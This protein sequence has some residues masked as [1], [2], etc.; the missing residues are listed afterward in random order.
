MAKAKQNAVVTIVHG[1]AYEKINELTKPSRLA[2]ARRIGA[3]F[4]TMRPAAEWPKDISFPWF[5]MNLFQKLDEWDRII[6]MDA[7]LIVSPDC[8]NLFDLV[9]P[10]HLGAFEEGKIEG[11]QGS[12]LAALHDYDIKTKRPYLGSYFNSGLMV[13][14]K[15]HQH[16]FIWPDNNKTVDNYYEQS[17]L[18]AR[19]FAEYL[20]VMSLDYKFNR[21]SCMDLLTGE[22]RHAAHIIHYAGECHKMK[23][24]EYPDGRKEKEVHAEPL[25]YDLIKDDLKAW[26][27]KRPVKRRIVV[28]CSGGI[29][30]VVCSEPILRYA[31]EKLY[32]DEREKTSFTILTRYRKIFEHL[33]SNPNV[34]V[35]S[36]DGEYA[37]DIGDWFKKKFGPT[38]PVAHWKTHP[39]SE[40]VMRMF[41]PYSAIHNL[42]FGMISLLRDSIPV[43]HKTPRLVVTRADEDE[44]VQADRAMATRMDKDVIVH[45]GTGWESKTFPVEYWTEIINRLLEGRKRVIIIGKGMNAEHGVLPVGWKPEY[46]GSVI[47]LRDKLSMGA[48]FAAIKSAPVLLTND[49]S[50]VHI[51]GAFDNWI[52]MLATCKRPDLVFPFRHGTTSYK[53]RAVYKK[54]T[55]ELNRPTSP[56]L[57]TIDELE[58]NILDYLETPERVVEVVDEC[59]FKAGHGGAV[60]REQVGVMAK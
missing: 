9:P 32:A 28:E 42:D 40:H 46:G 43:E 53:T 12:L 14:S 37:T 1:E 24:H 13:L 19:A 57:R 5:K 3:K 30:D 22:D 27:E 38:T 55:C 6:F 44:L 47:D 26:D 17:L 15:I 29:G 2:Y 49:S 41:I 20:P 8:P 34:E 60:D 35:T 51:A 4:D 10:T 16:L 59:L 45:P 48:L 52:V 7:D 54:L 31:I 58:G 33:E 23:I 50:P 25:V 18:N 21:M 39:P 56:H 11:R 36:A